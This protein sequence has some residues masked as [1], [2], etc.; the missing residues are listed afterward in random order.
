TYSPETEHYFHMKANGLIIMVS[1]FKAI[2]EHDPNTTGIVEG[3]QRD[4]ISIYYFETNDQAKAFYEE[5]KERVDYY[6][7]NYGD[8]REIG[9]SGKIVYIG[10][11]NAIKAA[12]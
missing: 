9:K 2:V 1:G 6:Q 8:L 7:D 5:N 10:T 4:Q 11:P 3:E 12:Q